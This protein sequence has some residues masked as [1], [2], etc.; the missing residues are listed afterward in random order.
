MLTCLD[1]ILLLSSPLPS[2]LLPS[3][4]LPPVGYTPMH[5]AVLCGNV[6][7]MKLLHA[8]GADIN[9]AVSSGR[10]LRMV[11]L[12]CNHGHLTMLTVCSC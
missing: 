10:G 2:H 9:A 8:A 7:T 4:A 5:L 3:L 12:V 1:F 6:Q 11:V